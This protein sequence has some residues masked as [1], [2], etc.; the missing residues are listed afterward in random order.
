MGMT[1]IQKQL[2]DRKAFGLKMRARGEKDQDVCYDEDTLL[3]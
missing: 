1:E 3:R 2:L